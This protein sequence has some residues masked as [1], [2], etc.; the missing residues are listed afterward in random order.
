[1]KVV[2]TFAVEAEFAAWRKL[3]VF[4]LIDYQ[5]LKLLRT[6]IGDAEVTVLITGVGSQAAALAMDLMMR[7][8]DRDMYFDVCISSGWAGALCDTLSVGEIIGPK[9]LIAGLKHVD[10]SEERLRVDA[11]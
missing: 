2:V 4:N 11:E 6:K 7:M 5:G 1:M 8:A 3:H 9:E 10:L